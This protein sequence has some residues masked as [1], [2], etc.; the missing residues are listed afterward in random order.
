VFIF[1][2]PAFAAT[3]FDVITADASWKKMIEL[4]DIEIAPNRVVMDYLNLLVNQNDLNQT[5]KKGELDKEK[6]KFVAD[7]SKDFLKYLKGLIVAHQVNK[8]TPEPTNAQFV[9]ITGVIRDPVA[10]AAKTAP[11]SEMEKNDSRGAALYKLWETWRSDGFMKIVINEQIDLMYASL[12][13]KK[14]K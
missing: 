2:V 9:Y 5:I 11:V 4:F 14:K 12:Q 6:A 7:N 8:I 1:T 3:K 10:Q 13:E